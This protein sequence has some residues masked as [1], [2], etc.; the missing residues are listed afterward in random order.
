[1]DSLAPHL[2]LVSSQA[3]RLLFTTLSLTPGVSCEPPPAVSN[4]DYYSSNRN[5]FQY[6]TVVT[7]RCLTGP[8]REKQFDLVGERSISC[9]SKDDQLGV[10]SSPP[11]RCISAKVENGIRLSGNRSLFSLNETV[12]F[13][14][15]PGFVMRG[16]VQCWANNTRV[17]ELPSCSRGEFHPLRLCWGPCPHPPK[18][19]NRHH[20]GGHASPCLPGMT[21]T[22]TCNL[23]YLLLGK[24]FA[25]CTQQRTWSQFDYYCKGNSL[26]CWVY[27]KLMHEAKKAERSYQRGS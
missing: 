23:G 3:I 19:H 8:D 24:A 25:F 17:H 6:A 18:I 1:I 15:Q 27:G 20:I 10:W 7:Y 26:S 12:R 22:Y 11:P 4:G 13:R 16:I 2:L 9:T 5:V 14:C 21:V